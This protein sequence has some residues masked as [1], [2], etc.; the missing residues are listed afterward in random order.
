MA[1]GK[2]KKE[3]GVVLRGAREQNTPTRVRIAVR[4][5]DDTMV[6]ERKQ[7]RQMK[8]NINWVSVN[9][10]QPKVVKELKQAAEKLLAWC[11]RCF[12]AG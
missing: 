7:G 10:G 6:L 8:G 5:F 11:H 9:K 1:Q 12:T 2:E 4:W 3:N